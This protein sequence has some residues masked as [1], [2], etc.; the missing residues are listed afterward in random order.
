MYNWIVRVRD[1]DRR[2]IKLS[3]VEFI[4]LGSLSKES[5]CIAAAKGVRKSSNSLIHWLPETWTKRSFTVRL[6]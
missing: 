1:N 3:Q 6:M 5:P 2:N 4:D